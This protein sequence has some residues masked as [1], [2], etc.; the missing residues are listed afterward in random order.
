LKKETYEIPAI[1]IIEF[2]LEE[3]IAS[4]SSPDGAFSGDEIAGGMW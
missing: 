2:T 3:A 4:S 1:E